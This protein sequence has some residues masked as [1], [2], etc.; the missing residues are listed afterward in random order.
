MRIENEV[1]LTFNDC[2]VVQIQCKG[3]DSVPDNEAVNCFVY[4]VMLL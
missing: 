3:R 4:E 1:F 2:D